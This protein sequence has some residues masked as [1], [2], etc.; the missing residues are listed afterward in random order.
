LTR[1][2]A[3]DERRRGFTGTVDLCGCVEIKIAISMA[4]PHG[5]TEK[6]TPA[7]M[8][9]SLHPFRWRAGPRMA[10]FQEDD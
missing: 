3:S 9:A 2:A 1:R 4:F 10:A 7:R 5:G 6:S 8:T